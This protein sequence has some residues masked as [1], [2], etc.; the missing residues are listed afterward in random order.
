MRSRPRLA[1]AALFALYLVGIGRAQAAPDLS[2]TEQRLLASDADGS[3]TFGY[4]IGAPGDTNGD[5]YADII[6]GDWVSVY[7]YRGSASGIDA[8][9]EFKIAP[10]NGYSDE[11]GKQVD[12]AGDVN[13]DGYADIVVG[14]PSTRGTLDSPCSGSDC[15]GHTGAA[16]VYY[17]SAHGLVT[18]TRAELLASTAGPEYC[19]G[20]AVSGIGDLNGDGF[21]DLVVGSTDAAYVYYGGTSGIAV[22]TEQKIG[23]PDP[24]RTEYPFFGY[25]AVGGAGDVNGD[26]YDDLV[27]GAVDRAYLYYGGSAGVDASIGVT[28][29]PPDGS[30][31]DG[32]GFSVDG[33]GD[34]NGD[35]YDDVVVGEYGSDDRGCAYIYF[36]AVDGLAAVPTVTLTASDREYNNYFGYSVSSAG[37]LDGDGYS[38]VLVGARGNMSAYAYYGS[39]AGPIESSEAELT[40]SSG[41][42]LDFGRAVTGIGDGNGDG[43]GDIMVSAPGDSTGAAYLFYG[44]C[45]DED[46]DGSCIFDDCDDAD[47]ARAPGA[48]EVCNGIDDDCDGVVDGPNSADAGTYQAD[49]DGDGVTDPDSQVTACGPPAGY[50]V[51][52]GE[53]DCDDSDATIYPGAEEV[54]GDGI[55]QD[56][57]GADAQVDDGTGDTDTAI[58]GPKDGGDGDSGSSGGCGCASQGSPS[59]LWLCGLLVVGS[60]LRRRRGSARDR[61]ARADER[62]R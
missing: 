10:P 16:F 27:V 17:G 34:V 43:F 3:A 8:S 20:H 28:L 56:C 2:A 61:D 49:S 39:D 45:T 35:C 24:S 48:L 54:A 26:G 59:E 31:A 44:A 30:S 14:A 19:Y 42:A 1:F 7:A 23:D 32:F 22:A 62:N 57:D 38:D 53:S 46:G 15:S 6:V 51:A 12:G 4:S 50:A 41:A 9:T 52:S 13:G 47:P 36:G 55:D 37:D 5:G 60:L 29:T 21:A 40:A 58:R 33:A 18:S 11:F 25:Y